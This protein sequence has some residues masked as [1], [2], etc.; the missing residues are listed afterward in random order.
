MPQIENCSE[1]MKKLRECLN[2]NLV[3][4]KDE[5]KKSVQI[6]DESESSWND[7][8][9]KVFKTNFDNGIGVINKLLEKMGIY[10]DNLHELQKGLEVYESVQQYNPFNN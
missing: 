2:E 7:D 4:L 9:Y 5:M 1:G 10:D 3:V 8:Q 6:V